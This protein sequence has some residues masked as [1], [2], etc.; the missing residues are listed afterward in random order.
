MDVAQRDHDA[1][2]MRVRVRRVSGLIRVFEHSNAI[3]LKQ[4][5][6]EIRVGHYWVW[7]HG[8]NLLR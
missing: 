3:V 6:V 8:E 1:I 4:H 2:G 7:A 5:S